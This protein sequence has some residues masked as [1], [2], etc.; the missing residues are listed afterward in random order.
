MTGCCGR[1][2]ERNE[3]P[4]WALAQQ[5]I[6][7]VIDLVLSATDINE[8]VGQVDMNALLDRVDINALLEKVDLNALMDRVDLNALLDHVDLN[9]RHGPGGHQPAAGTRRR[10]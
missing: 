7:R 6:E 9:A 2:D 3:R 4:G 10:Q 1:W 5:V 8:I